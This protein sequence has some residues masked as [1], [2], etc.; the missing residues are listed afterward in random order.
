MLLKVQTYFSVLEIF[1]LLL[2]LLGHPLPAVDLDLVVGVDVEELA[3][4]DHCEHERPLLVLLLPLLAAT[5]TDAPPPR[6]LVYEVKYH[7]AILLNRVVLRV[8][9]VVWVVRELENRWHHV[10]S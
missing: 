7:V 1:I 3:D 8:V 9:L 2:L 10:T 5:A 4:V 6:S